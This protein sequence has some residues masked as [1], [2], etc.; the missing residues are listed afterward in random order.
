MFDGQ[1]VRGEVCERMPVDYVAWRDML[2]EVL[3]EDLW[4]DP[5]FF[6]PGRP[7]DTT[8]RIRMPYMF[9]GDE[10]ADHQAN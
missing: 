4:V 3:V 6:T 7:M 1:V 5:K 9:E 2:P 8:G 10:F